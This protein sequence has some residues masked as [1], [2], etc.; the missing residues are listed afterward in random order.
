MRGRDQPWTKKKRLSSERVGQIRR[1]AAAKLAEFDYRQGAIEISKFAEFLGARVRY[2][3]YDDGELA[4]MLVR[5][6]NQQPII[7][8]NSS[9]PPNRQRFTIAHECGHLLLHDQ[10]LFVDEKLSVVRNRDGKSSLAI[11]AQEVEANQ[12]AAEVLMP[13]NNIIEE[14]RDLNFDI[15]DE[16][17]TIIM[18]KKYRVSRQAMSYRIYNIV[19]T[20]IFSH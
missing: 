6:S 13:Y 12:F 8:V 3:P 5:Q 17:D 2:A 11:S 16:S 14:I 20:L 19:S 10:E 7:A 15:E 9:H 4:G 1:L 18:A